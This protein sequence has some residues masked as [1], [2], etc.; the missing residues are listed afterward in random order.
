MQNFTGLFDYIFSV[1]PSWRCLSPV[2]RLPELCD[3]W[4]PGEQPHSGALHRFVQRSVT[5]GPA[6]GAEQTHAAD[7]RWGHQQ[8]YPCGSGN[9]NQTQG[10]AFLQKIC[11]CRYCHAPK[12][13]NTSWHDINRAAIYI[14]GIWV[15]HGRA[16]LASVLSF[17]TGQ[18]RKMIASTSL[19]RYCSFCFT[20]VRFSKETLKP[21][22]T[23]MENLNII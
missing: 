5:V 8:I 20:C 7:A 4:L 17:T 13:K 9:S 19:T 10:K 23:E 6:H 22:C 16:F 11:W 2:H 14:W 1:F 18:E 3:P 15:V 21:F 12:P